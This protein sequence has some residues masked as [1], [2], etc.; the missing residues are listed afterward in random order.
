MIT[1]SFWKDAADES[2]NAAAKAEFFFSQSRILTIHHASVFIIVATS[3]EIFVR[4]W[5][6]NNEMKCSLYKVLPPATYRNVNEVADV[7]CDDESMQCEH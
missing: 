5:D 1:I 4:L 2:F 3:S 6:R 7:I